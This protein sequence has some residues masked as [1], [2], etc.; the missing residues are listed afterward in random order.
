MIFFEIIE[1]VRISE[2][3]KEKDKKNSV[4]QKIELLALCRS[5]TDDKTVWKEIWFVCL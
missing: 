1:S 3:M 5:K 2:K 4:S